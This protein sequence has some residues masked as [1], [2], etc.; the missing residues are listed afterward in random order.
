[1]A[2]VSTLRLV[3]VPSAPVRHTALWRGTV[4]ARVGF[5]GMERFL[6]PDC[7]SIL[8]FHLFQSFAKFF[9]LLLLGANLTTHIKTLRISELHEFCPE[10]KNDT[11]FT[12]ILLLLPRPVVMNSL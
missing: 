11:S 10:Y 12:T 1:M 3:A 7:P 2:S 6:G 5:L 9:H 4:S 8:V